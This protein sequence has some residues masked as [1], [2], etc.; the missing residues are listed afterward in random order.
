MAP[1]LGFM[2]ALNLLS[3]ANCSGLP[4]RSRTRRME[5]RSIKQRRAVN[6]VRYRRDPG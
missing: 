1:K 4:E 6:L 2:A 5:R 3:G